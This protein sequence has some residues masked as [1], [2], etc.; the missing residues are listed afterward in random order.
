[1]GRN[2]ADFDYETSNEPDM[3]NA[4]ANTPNRTVSHQDRA[5]IASDVAKMFGKK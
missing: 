4:N 5:K 1:M 3:S 2:K